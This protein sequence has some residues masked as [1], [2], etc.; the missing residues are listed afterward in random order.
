MKLFWIK[1]GVLLYLWYEVSA[2]LYL[3]GG[4]TLAL[5]LLVCGAGM[6]HPNLPIQLVALPRILLL[7]APAAVWFG[8]AW[9]LVPEAAAVYP[10]LALLLAALLALAGAAARYAVWRYSEWFSQRHAMLRG[11]VV[12]G[13]ILLMAL[14]GSHVRMIGLTVIGM[15]AALP[16][17]LGWRVMGPAMPGY[18][19]AGNAHFNEKV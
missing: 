13:S 17:R 19:G 5:S 18:S 11:A 7:A 15:L 12:P 9:W 3:T 10:A 6:M 16:L 4:T 1:L 2:E 8:L 14:A